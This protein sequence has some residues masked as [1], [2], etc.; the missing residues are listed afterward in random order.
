MN[1]FVIGGSSV[2]TLIYVPEIKSI[3]DD[4]S[5]WATNIIT[6]IGGTGA[7]KALCLD[8]IGVNTTL[9]TDVGNDDKRN[10][11]STFFAQT[12]VRTRFVE[13]DKT[14]THTNIM[15]SFGKRISIFTTYPSVLP[16]IHPKIEQYIE[17][18]DVIFLNINEFC[19]QYIPMLKKT[20]KPII[21]D[22]H[23]YTMG[24]PHHQDFIDVATILIA[25]GVYINNQEQFLVDQIQN[26]KSIAIVTN[27]NQGLKALDSSLTFYHI[28][29]NTD[30]DYVDSNGAGDSFCSGFMTKYFE[31]KNV[32][33]SLKF[34]TICGAI[35]CTSH[36]L[37]NQKYTKNDIEKLVDDVKILDIFTIDLEHTNY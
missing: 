15:H 36:D 8:S 35:A 12:N 28:A 20:G 29:G 1:S 30:I 16:P 7:G 2:D 21:V 10:Q 27:G 14:T 23:D 5:L 3:A 32:L 19:R 26:G 25:S 9:I 4:M 17:E 11:I 24:N 37:F 31:T 34:G 33:E 22:I 6:S 13:T 18:T